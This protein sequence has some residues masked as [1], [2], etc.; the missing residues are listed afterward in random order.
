MTGRF[1]TGGGRP[2]QYWLECDRYVLFSYGR[3]GKL[4]G[5]G[6]DAD[7]HHER[8]RVLERF[9]LWEFTTARETRGIVFGCVVA[10]VIAF[11][12]CLLRSK[13]RPG[14]QFGLAKV[15]AINAVTA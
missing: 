10:G 1:W 3:N 8:D 13:G 6:L 15:L 7:L 4:G 9:T 5:T 14:D 11:P 2:F 12:L